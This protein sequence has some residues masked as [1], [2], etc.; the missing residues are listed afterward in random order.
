M[1]IELREITLDYPDGL[2]IIPRILK[3]G[4]E[5]QKKKGTERC[6]S[7]GSEDGKRVSR[8]GKRKSMPNFWTRDFKIINMYGFETIPL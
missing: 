4:K 1:K 5:R 7:D 6:N 3:S 8:D 2:Q